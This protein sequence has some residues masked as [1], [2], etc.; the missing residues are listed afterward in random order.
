MNRT[1]LLVALALGAGVGLVFALWPQLDIAISQLFFDPARG[2]F[3]AQ[4]S[5]VAA[6]LRDFFN[7]ATAALVAPAVLALLLKLVLPRRRMLRRSTSRRSRLLY[8]RPRRSP[9]QRSTSNSKSRGSS[10]RSGS[11]N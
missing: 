8:L 11:L 3:P 5:T 4:Y 1:G 7:Y 10:W 2:T 6:R 9:N